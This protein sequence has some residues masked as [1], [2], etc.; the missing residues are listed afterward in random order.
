MVDDEKKDTMGVTFKETFSVPFLNTARSSSKQR[1]Q[2]APQ[3]REGFGFNQLRR[4]QRTQIDNENEPLKWTDSKFCG[5]CGIEITK[6][7]YYCFNC[8]WK[9]PIKI[10][11]K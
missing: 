9:I 3:F 8:G 10:V 6:I 7:M 2:D 11:S 4:N 5:G 1:S